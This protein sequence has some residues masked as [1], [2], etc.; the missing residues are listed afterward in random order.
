MAQNT[1]QIRPAEPQDSATILTFIKEL[2]EYEKLA[3]E[4]LATEALVRKALFGSRP[5]AEVLI[6]EQSGEPV[7]FALFFPTFSTFLAKAGIYLEDLYVREAARG[8]GIGVALMSAVAQVAVE[9][10][11]GRFE[12]SVLNWNTPSIEFYASL[13]AKPLSE[14]TMQRITGSALKALAERGAPSADSTRET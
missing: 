1:L 9:R 2:A 10:G 12:W 6:A 14:W 7:G 13:G 8:Q 4:V 5:A 11:A 3:H